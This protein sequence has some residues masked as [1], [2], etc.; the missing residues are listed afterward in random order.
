ME[1]DVNTLIRRYETA[2]TERTNFE[3]HWQESA[4]LVLPT[5][6]FTLQSQPQGLRRRDFIFSEVA[7]LANES[8]AAALHGMLTNPALRWMAIMAAD[9][10]VNEDLEAQSWFY[11]ITNRMLAYFANPISGFA[12]TSHEIYLDLGA[13]GNGVCLMRERF[14]R[15]T[16]QARQL[17]NFYILEDDEGIT[18]DQYRA[19]LMTARD[20]VKTFA[21]S[22]P[23][24][25]RNVVDLARN[26]KTA[27]Q[28]LTVLHGV[29]V[30]DERDFHS[31]TFTNM[32]WASVYMML[33]ENDKSVMHRGG[34]RENPYL[35]PRWSLAPEECYGRGPAMM[36]LPAIKLLNAMEKDIMIASEQS[37]RPPINVFA[38]SLEGPISTKPGSINYL[39]SGAREAPSPMNLGT[40]PDI[41]DKRLEQHEAKVEEAFFL[42]TLRLP[43]RDR[44]TAEEIITRRQQ[45]LLK[46]S[47]VM[48]R[49]IAEWLDP[50]IKR[51]FNWMFRTGK[52]PPVPTILRGRRFTIAYNSP[53]A[54][55]QKAAESQA[56]LQ[57]LS[58]A[59]L[60]IQAD[61]TIITAEVNPSLA[62][63]AIWINSGA[64]PKLLNTPEVA[65]TIRQQIAEQQQLASGASAARDLAAAGRDA[66]EATGVIGQ[67]GAA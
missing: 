66:A 47:P 18:T 33:H 50:S 39:R 24:P 20:I 41:G 43:Q 34:F 31:P 27:E 64:D 5:R 12:T 38:N 28:R 23:G 17:S 51:L 44:M 49:V 36:V 22:D 61:P 32:P 35:M 42:D 56:I 15:F 25:P 4:D 62:F 65:A 37:V 30:N 7:P 63:R 21:A 10:A 11:E 2:V 52:F 16:F 58:T 13:F 1:L 54:S 9:A 19:F 29:V 60:L 14:D 57:A 8:L 46:A 6:D 40:R 26:A 48:S 59:Q 53:M 67:I 45:G 3:W 55:S